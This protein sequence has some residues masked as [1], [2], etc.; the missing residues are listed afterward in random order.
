AFSSIISKAMTRDLTQRFQ[1]TAD[2]IQALDSWMRSGTA[3]SVPPAADAAAAGLALAGGAA[4]A[5]RGPMGSQTNLNPG[6]G[7]SGNWASSQPQVEPASLPK[8]SNAGLIAALALVGVVVMGGAAFAAYSV[9]GKKAEPAAASSSQP[10]P[11]AAAPPEL[12]AKV[13]IAPTPP[14]AEAPSASPPAAVSAAPAP[15]SADA[16]KPAPVAAP[17]RPVPNARPA[18]AGKPA[19]AKPAKPAAAK[20]G[21]GTPDFGY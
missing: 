6:A 2:F 5:P 21:G 14:A 12:A 4:S 7:T 10:S 8:K 9:L 15:A 13:E 20:P 11:P 1:T 17:V 18:S 19:P 3:V 16:S